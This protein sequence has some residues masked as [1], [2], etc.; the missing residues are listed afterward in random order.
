MYYNPLFL[1][2]EDIQHS[3]FL[4][5][6][7]GHLHQGIP[8]ASLATKIPSPAYEKSGRGRKPFLKVEGGIALM[9]LKHYL[10]LSDELLIERLNTDWC[11]QYFCGVQ[12]GLRKIKDKNI[13]SWWRTYLGNRLNIA[14][15]QSVLIENWK[16]YMEQTHVTLMDA[17]CYESHLRYPTSVKLLWESIVKVYGVVQQ[18]RNR[19]KLRCSRSNYRKHKQLFMRYQRSRKK[20]KRK[21]KKLRK[22]L[23][24]YLLRLLQGLDSLQNK[25]QF[26]YSNKEKKLLATIRTVYEQQHELVY[27][28]SEKIAHR[29]V[30]ISKPYIRPIVRGKEINPVEFGA[31]VHKVQ[32]S[33][34]S[35]IEHLSYEAFNEGTRLK[36][37]VAFHQKHFGKLSQLGA[38]AIYATNENR[39]YCSKLGIATSFV[40]KGNGGKLA[41]QKQA[42]RS[43]LSVVRGTVLEGSFGNEKNHYL[44]NKIKAKTQPTELAWIFFG[45]LAA[46]VSIISNRIA[47]TQKRKR[48]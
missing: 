21:E 22:Q 4:S 20:A 45:M 47:N 12:L 37:T 24:K 38:D 30:S 39:K 44:L 29:I 9:I 32:V 17:T 27:G 18:K 26:T 31:K 34:I 15:L 40:A 36:Q 19:L 33:G 16:P 8:F 14:E 3:I 10:G 46:N 13:V 41:N 23:L 2:T 48:A 35:F 7:L 11:M 43:A 6:D 25:H 5:T 28:S 42:M 1:Q